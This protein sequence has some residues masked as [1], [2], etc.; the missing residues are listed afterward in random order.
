MAVSGMGIDDVIDWLQAEH[1]R[2]VM[3]LEEAGEEW[4]A[5]LPPKF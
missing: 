1:T 2:N 5:A 3:N 4:A